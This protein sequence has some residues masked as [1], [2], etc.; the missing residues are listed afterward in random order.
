MA[1]QIRGKPWQDRP[2]KICPAEFDRYVLTHEVTGFRKAL[3]KRCDGRIVQVRRTQPEV[4]N[5]RQL[6]LLR[7]RRERPCGRR[8]AEKRDDVAAFIRSPRR[9]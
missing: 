2:L 4:S 6:R 7:A 1:D 5:L 8:T 9:Q 3:K